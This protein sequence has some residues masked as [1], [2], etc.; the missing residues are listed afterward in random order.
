MHVPPKPVLRAA[1]RWLQHLPNS[2]PA[3]MRAV[4]TTN[5]EFSDIGPAQY[6]AAYTWLRD[7]GLLHDQ[8]TALPPEVRV[9]EAMLASSSE[10]WIRDADILVREPLEIPADAVTVAD[11]LGLSPMDAFNS[12]K[13]TWQKIDLEVRARVGSAG[14]ERLVELLKQ[15]TDSHVEHVALWSDGHGYDIAVTKA[16]FE[17]HLEVKT[18]TRKNRI[19]VYIT[20]N[21]FETMK[22]DPNWRM[23]VVQLT[24]SFTVEAITSVPSS[25]LLL[26]APLDRGPYGQ[27]ES[28]RINLPA[29]STEKGLSFLRPVICRAGSM[30]ISGNCD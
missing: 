20:R 28:C 11:S 9:F 30:L 3:R 25:W 13:S 15:E 6:E 10:P 14:E 5:S 21:E 2:G 8:H 19:S 4:F 17:A 18:T 24:E 1:V 12:I 7:V 22:L 26:H 16:T 27:W 23:V 29:G